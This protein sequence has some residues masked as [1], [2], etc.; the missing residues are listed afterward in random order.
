MSL[1]LACNL[2]SMSTFLWHFDIFLGFSCNSCF[3]SFCYSHTVSSLL[4]RFMTLFAL[5]LSDCGSTW[6]GP[7]TTRTRLRPPMRSSSWR[8]PRGSLPANGKPNVRS[9]SLPCSSRTPS[10]ESGITDM[11]SEW[12]LYCHVLMCSEICLY[13]FFKITNIPQRLHTQ[14]AECV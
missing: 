5:N 7:S 9:G 2:A 10:L 12:L 8:R 6:P 1:L 4:S 13:L 11:P 3:C 14:C